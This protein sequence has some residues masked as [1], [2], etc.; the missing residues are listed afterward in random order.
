MSLSEHIIEV[1]EG[2][3]EAE[4]IQRSYE[5]PVVVDFWASWCVPCRELGPVLERL[6]IEAGGGFR[7]AKVNVDQN[8]GLAIRFGVQG[9]PAI[10][11]FSQGEVKAEFT[12]AQ[13]ESAVRRFIQRLAPG[14][15]DRALQEASSLLA[16][17]HWREAEAS[18][19]AVLDERE[20][21]AA[22][23]GLVK[24]L[25][26]QGKGLP[27]MKVLDK[28]PAG[29]EWAAAEQLK[30]L[31]ELMVEAESASAGDD[32]QDVLQSSLL[33]AGRLIE[34]GNLEAAMDGLLDILRQDKGYR[35]GLPRRVMLALFVLLGDEDPITRQYRD[36]LASVLF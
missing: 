30:P 19:R 20:S 22:A 8:P 11:A 23:L 10:K 28:F 24:A 5:L 16:T 25:L 29:T 33:Q 4:V 17:R 13:P 3:F 36:E 14:P 31:A 9:I 27:A 18:F 2:D 15:V 34:R 26:M 32:D 6:A 12:G 21:S 35:H 1:G 7:L